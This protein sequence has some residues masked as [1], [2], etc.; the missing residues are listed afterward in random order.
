MIKNFCL[1]ELQPER[2]PPLSSQLFPERKR[3]EDRC[4]KKQ[5]KYRKRT[6]KHVS[7][8]RCGTR[9]RYKIP[10]PFRKGQA[11]RAVIAQI[12]RPPRWSCCCGYQFFVFLFWVFQN[13]FEFPVNVRLIP[14]TADSE[15]WTQTASWNP[16]D[17][18]H[19]LCR[20]EGNM[21]IF[22]FRFGELNKNRFAGN[23]IVPANRKN[24]YLVC[25]KIVFPASDSEMYPHRFP[26]ES[27]RGSSR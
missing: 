22:F 11:I 2:L 13:P 9:C 5:Q 1:P 21:S 20:T 4:R 12:H 17:S 26:P 18:V 3:P 25:T 14:E 6:V 15:G 19:S 8:C 16:P 7:C 24:F 23:W 27:E 10:E